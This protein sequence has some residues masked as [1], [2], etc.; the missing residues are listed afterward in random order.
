MYVG[1]LNLGESRGHYQD[2]ITSGLE[3]AQ[4]SSLELLAIQKK[5]LFTF[6]SLLWV[7]AL[8]TSNIVD[9]VCESGEFWEW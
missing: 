9:V 7:L 8:E 3:T 1:L 2:E 6:V 4:Q 5:L